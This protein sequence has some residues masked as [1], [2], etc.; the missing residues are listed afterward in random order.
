MICRCDFID[1]LQSRTASPAF[2]P[3]HPSGES[4]V[5]PE[6]RVVRLSRRGKKQPVDLRQSS[7]IVLRPQAAPSS[8]SVLRRLQDISGVRDS[9]RAV[10]G[11]RKGEA[12]GTVLVGRQS[13]LHQVLRFFRALGHRF[14]S[15]TQYP[16]YGLRYQRSRRRA[17]RRSKPSSISPSSPASISTWRCPGAGC[18]GSE[19][20]PRSSLLYRS[21]KPVRSHTKSL[22][23]FLRLF[24]KQKR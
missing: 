5:I 11:L 9:T 12:G 19:K 16:W 10:P 23:R 2:V 8:R 4:L 24:R 13:V 15:G 14:P 6:P 3:F 18:I 17:P 21:R 20:V 1:T 7:S 22:I